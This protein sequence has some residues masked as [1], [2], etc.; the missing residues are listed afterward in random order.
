[1]C[2]G[3]SR[4]AMIVTP[5]RCAYITWP[6]QVARW[7]HSSWMRVIHLR[8]KEGLAAWHKGE[9]EI[10]LVNPEQ[11]QKLCPILFKGKT[12]IPADTFVWDECSQV[13][14]PA[15]KR[16]KA[17]TP[18]LHL[19]KQKLGLTGTP[20]PNTY[21]DLWN[22]AFILDGG[23][24]LGKSFFH[25]RQTWFKSDYMGYHWEINPGAKE[26]IDAKLADLC[27]V[28]LGDDY[29]ELPTCNAEDIDVP[30]PPEAKALY[31][32]MERDLLLQRQQGDVVALSAAA[33]CGKLLQMT[34][35]FVYD[36]NGGVFH[37]HSAKLDA[38]K[39]L[40]AKHKDEPML[41]LTSYNHETAAVLEAIPS[42]VEFHERDM[43]KWKR[44]EIKTWICKAAQMSHGIDGMQLG[45]RIAVWYTPT[46]SWEA[47][48]Q[49]NARLVRPGQSYETIIYRLLVP[50]SID[51]CVVEA[52]KGKSD[53]E[54]GL[55]QAL[56]TLQNLHPNTK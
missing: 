1:M 55:L 51:W 4:A 48:T 53:T 3:K 44:G 20:C 21:L 38:L 50:D 16:V 12:E 39:K 11:L 34:G 37:V 41:V 8:T 18:Y 32:Q 22:Q 49:T 54:S 25:F 7:D 17:L 35:G 24:R 36:E 30:L 42:A 5:I 56:K 6:D 15:S 14:N 46:W 33:L 9:F 27:L 28:M 40:R 52:V 13:K 45:G 23:K 19:F 2:D 26:I 10:A 47:Y 43:D 29:L 31:K